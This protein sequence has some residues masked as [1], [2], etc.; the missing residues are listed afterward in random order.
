M[1]YILSE[2]EY[3]RLL[4][5]R[6]QRQQ[7][8]ST[9]TAAL[10]ELCTQAAMHIPVTRPQ[11]VP[12]PGQGM[13]AVSALQGTGIAAGPGEAPAAPVPDRGRR[14]ATKRTLFFTMVQ[15]PVKGWARAGNAYPSRKAASDWVPFVRGASR[16]LAV[17]VSQVT[18]RFEGGKVTEQ[19]R[20]VLDAKF[21]LDV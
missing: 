3:Q 14:A 16:G 7:R 2:D 11:D 6:Q 1:Q 8:E 18:V 10:Q 21:N 13:V 15:H 5:Q 19:S 12:A 4:G 9:D 17:K 20:R